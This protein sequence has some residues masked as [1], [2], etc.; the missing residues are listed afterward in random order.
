MGLFKGYT[1][2]FLLTTSKLICLKGPVG[3][4]W[5]KG[6]WFRAYGRKVE[7]LGKRRAQEGLGS[8]EALGFRV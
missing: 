7:G 5:V 4:M 2:S 6:S 3:Y 8:R 1:P